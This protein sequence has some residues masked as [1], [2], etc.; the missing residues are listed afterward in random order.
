[1]V[2]SA[3]VVAY[4][5]GW[6]LAFILTG[7]SILLFKVYLKR[8]DEWE[9]IKKASDDVQEKAE[10]IAEEILFKIQEVRALGGQETDEIRFKAALKAGKQDVEK[11]TK[12]SQVANGLIS[13]GMFIFCCLGFYIGSLLI[14]P[15][16]SGG[17]VLNVTF[18]LLIVM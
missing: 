18:C 9:K 15:D 6:K 16:F 11:L 4:V 5:Q 10:R 2:I 17:G 1:M 8:F 12:F 3:M 13:F 7:L 14:T